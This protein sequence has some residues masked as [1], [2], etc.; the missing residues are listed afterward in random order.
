M[1]NKQN[2]KGRS[3][4]GPQFVKLDYGLLDSPA[5]HHLS[6]YAFKLLV[7]IWRRHNGYNNGGIPYSQREACKLL[8]CGTHRAASCFQELQDKGFLRL[9][10]ASDFGLK[11]REA[12]EWC[13]TAE[14]YEDDPPSRDFKSWLPDEK[15]NTDAETTSDRCSH[16]TR[17]PQNPSEK[18]LT[19]AETTPVKGGSANVTDAHTTSLY[20]IPP[21]GG[22]QPSTEQDTLRQGVE[23]W[24]YQQ[25]RQNGASDWHGRLAAHIGTSGKD[26]RAWQR[27]DGALAS[28]CLE[29]LAYLIQ[30]GISRWVDHRKPMWATPT[31]VA[32]YT[33]DEWEEMEA[34]A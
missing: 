8:N 23:S 25:Y 5:W 16:D 22:D 3:R 18:A 31:I 6:P 27:G 1:A 12:R 13:I 26:L 17:A 21:S 34:A 29:R 14:A 7:A 15:Q 32:E 10:R 4:R 9:A 11:T 30:R 20:N 28:D 2:K 24:A 33:H 19:D